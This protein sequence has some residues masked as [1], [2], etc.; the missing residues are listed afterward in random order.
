MAVEMHD[1]PGGV[2]TGV[3]APGTNHGDSMISHPRER[4]LDVLLHRGH[5]RLL[6]L[7][8]VVMTAVVFNTESD[9][10]HGA[11]GL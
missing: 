10:G 5:T 2:D 8:A 3:G 4:T 1:L 7:P 11:M 6:G 9:A